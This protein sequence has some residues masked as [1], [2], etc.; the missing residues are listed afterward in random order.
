MIR[1]VIERAI[2][3]VAADRRTQVL[4]MAE[5]KRVMMLMIIELEG[6]E[7]YEKG[8]GDGG[9]VLIFVSTHIVG[10]RSVRGLACF[11]DC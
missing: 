7:L 1:E 10:I 9:P 6:F 11:P 8:S 5:E 2:V 3:D 4:V